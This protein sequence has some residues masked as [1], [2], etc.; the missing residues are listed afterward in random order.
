[1]QKIL[2]I[3]LFATG[4]AFGAKAQN[5]L[6]M[7]LD[8][9]IQNFYVDTV[10]NLLYAAGSNGYFG[11]KT[12]SNG[13]A[14]W[15]GASWDTLPNKL[16]ANVVS[17]CR[18]KNKLY[19]SGFFYPAPYNCPSR[20][21]M[22]WDLATAQWQL[23]GT[24]IWSS[25]A[26]QGVARM[27]IINNE[28]Y[29]YGAFDSICNKRASGVVKFDGTNWTGFN[30]NSDEYLVGIALYNG[31]LY[32][33]GQFTDLFGDPNM[34][35][36]IK[37][38][39]TN[40]VSTGANFNGATSIEAITVYKNELYVAGYFLKSDGCPG[41]NIVKYN[42]T[43]WQ[44]VNGGFSYH[45]FPGAVPRRMEVYND[46]LYIA[47]TFDQMGTMPAH[48]LVT[49]DGTEF[50]AVDNSINEPVWPV[51]VYKNKIYV[52][53]A[54]FS[55]G[56]NGQDTVYFMGQQNKFTPDTCQVFAVGVKETLPI[57]ELSIYPNPVASI[58]NI[59]DEQNE[60]QNSTVE[61]TNSLGQN[62][63]KVLFNNSIDVSSIQTGCYFITISTQDQKVLR[64]KFIK[65]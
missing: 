9:A 59:S 41:D 26:E 6:P 53:A 15:N 52:G 43:S 39:G 22:A 12:T 1:M 20:T 54:W 8:Q 35:F 63:V 3:L 11:G 47:G 23:V 34:D 17:M 57:K 45:G 4:F 40:W 64:F 29:F 31:E 49:Y 27:K 5:W 13:F 60:L 42:G 18:Y 51:T 48:Y 2:F 58:L 25:G 21:L 56:V 61:I 30:F 55:S 10:D 65:E 62:V 28:L 16:N 7:D 50:C 38:N 32:A 37:Y 14:I 19:V 46:K 33:C 44:E 36:L 24:G